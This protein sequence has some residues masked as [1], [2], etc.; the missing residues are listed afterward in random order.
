MIKKG[1]FAVKAHHTNLLRCLLFLLLISFVSACDNS[2]IKDQYA[3]GT[4]S[5]QILWPEDDNSG[6]AASQWVV[7]SGGQKSAETLTEAA[8]VIVSKDCIARGVVKI[9]VDVRDAY[10]NL[11]VSKQF[12]CNLGV[13]EILVPVGSGRLFII[14]GLG[15]GGKVRY[16]GVKDDVTIRAG[17][18]DIGTIQMER[19]SE[20]CSDNDGDGYYNEIDCGTVMDC[21]DNNA[22]IYPGAI[23]IC[24][25]GID[26]DCD[27]VDETCSI[28][29]NGIDDD[30]DGYTEN[31]GDCDDSDNTIHPDAIE[32]CG[33]GIDQDC[34][35][36]DAQCVITNSIGMTFVYIRAG[37]FNMG[38][39]V[40][41]PSRSDD[42]TQHQVTLTQSYY[43]QNTETTQGQ[44]QRVLG[45]NPSS[46]TNCGMNCPV[47]YVSWSD[48]QIFIEALNLLEQT[49]SYRLPTEA[50]WEYA[51]RA[52]SQSAFENGRITETGCGIDA[53][54]SKM[55][56]YCGNSSVTYNSCYDASHIDGP[57]CAGTHPVAQKNANRWG[58]YDMHGNLSE[59][60]SDWYGEFQTSSVKD[61]KG[62]PQDPL[63]RSSFKI[64]RGGNWRSSVGTCRSAF[65][66]RNSPE[67][68]SRYYGFRVVLSMD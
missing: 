2:A 53:N 52:G 28:D 4:A 35:G 29:P 20:F 31:Q 19:S 36:I 41:E 34:N 62:P 15:D 30:G 14:S 40:N 67:K 16:Y 56:W 13:G 68:R 47:D 57:S 1:L 48:A 18:N 65:R 22:D 23:E 8:S 33:D 42:E 32:N 10:E 7:S 17:S 60:C 46:F 54:L 63:S 21:N 55:G 37:T 26:Q 39:P 9:G 27:G 66:G 3:T 51:C 45:D 43:I 59:W 50:E 5:F 12:N 44:Y 11:I 6:I 61:P 38:S 64:L 24:E 25:D 49:D 58:L